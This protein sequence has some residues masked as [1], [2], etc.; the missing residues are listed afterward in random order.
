MMLQ[1]FSDGRQRRQ[2]HFSFVI[3][4]DGEAPASDI[5]N[6]TS[7]LEKV[8]TQ[9]LRDR[10]NS[11]VPLGMFL[12]SGVDSSL[13]CALLTKALGQSGK[14]FTIGFEGDQIGRATCRE[15]VCQYV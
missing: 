12:S 7:V 9:A 15:R 11:D 5:E 4:Q 1:V 8:L 3:D 2:R 6:Y 10:L 14:T 13:A